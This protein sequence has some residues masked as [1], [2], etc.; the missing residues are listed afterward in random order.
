VKIKNLR[1]WNVSGKKNCLT[2]AIVGRVFGESSHISFNMSV[3]SQSI[4]FYTTE[5][6]LKTAISHSEIKNSE[7][8]PQLADFNG[9]CR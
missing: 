8:L 9:R 2:I 6:Q 7:V 1:V 3:S 5:H 4:N